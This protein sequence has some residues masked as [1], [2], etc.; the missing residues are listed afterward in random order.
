MPLFRRLPRNDRGRDFVVGDIHGCFD[1]L[2]A[3]LRRVGFNEITDRLLS[4]GDLVDRGPASH[5]AIHWL[6]KPWFHAVRGNHEQMAIEAALGMTDRGMHEL[7]GGAWFYRLPVQQQKVTG[8]VFADLPYA[9]EVDT[10]AGTVGLVHAEVPGD[11]WEVFRGFLE[12]A[13]LTKP[14]PGN[15]DHMERFALWGRDIIR[16]R[17]TFAG[18]ANIGRVFVGHTVVPDWQR[19]HNV[20]FIDTGA[21]LGRRF[22]LVCLQSG[23][24]VQD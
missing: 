16:N 13:D 10:S 11:D 20:H 21:C 19:R 4:V 12:F 17:S 22:T 8:Q 2:S 23:Q 14:L 5:E 7:N 15:F 18:V 24:I 1:R 9:I 3:M 6:D